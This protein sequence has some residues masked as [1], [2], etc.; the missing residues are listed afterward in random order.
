MATIFDHCLNGNTSEVKRLLDRDVD[1]NQLD[2][3]GQTLLHL[4]IG[5]GYIGIVR[6]LLQHGADVHAKNRDGA[7]PLHIA[8]TINYGPLIVV[9]LSIGADANAQDNLGRTP[10]FEAVKYNRAD[11]VTILLPHTNLSLRD[12]DGKTVLENGCSDEIKKLIEEY[13]DDP[14]KEPGES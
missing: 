11:N 9:L 4:A 7:T 8:S 14:I 10:I 13:L 6:A 5:C 3:H 2:H 1:V 12:T